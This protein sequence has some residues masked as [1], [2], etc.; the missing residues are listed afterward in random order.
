MI[1]V[2]FIA[3]FYFFSEH[4][5][6]KSHTWFMVILIFSIVELAFDVVTVYTVNHLDTVPKLVNRVV[7]QVFLTFLSLLFYA[8]YKYLEVM[9]EEE[10]G[11][12][13]Q[14]WKYS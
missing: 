2:L 5:K 7:H 11:E 14:K 8:V 4:K 3:A 10:V 6:T 1:I 13:I 9:I 12:K